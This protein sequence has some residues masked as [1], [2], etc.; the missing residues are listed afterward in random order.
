MVHISKKR[1]LH[2]GSGIT[3][4]HAYKSKIFTHN[5]INSYALERQRR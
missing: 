3:I 2:E 1:L 5:K 4:E